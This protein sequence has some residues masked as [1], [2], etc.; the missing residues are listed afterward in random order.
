MKV[1]IC[2]N[3]D[4][5]SEKAADIFA[6]QIKNKPDSV[7]GLATGSTPIGMYKNLIEKNKSGEISFK[8]C[9]SFNL[10]EYYGI[11][12]DNCQSYRYF[13]N[14][15]FFKYIDIDLSRTNFPSAERFNEYDDMIEAAGGT[16]IQVLGI[17]CN[18]HIAFNEPDEYLI[19]STHIT[20]LAQKTI[21]ANARFFD[22]PASVPTKAI[23]MGMSSILKS[24][25]IIL[26]ASGKD[27]A[28]AVK[29]MLSGKITSYCP[30]SLINLHRDATVICDKQA[31]G[32]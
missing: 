8:S 11:S 24:K 22:S 19:S 25:K 23:T 17:G 9:K 5:M 13:M 4:E 31:G 18:G 16:D 28:E 20:N 7:L 12:P 10:D 3:Y 14:S 6:E 21:Q 2:E 15:N 32:K 27:K 30:A 1:I 29:T 26:L